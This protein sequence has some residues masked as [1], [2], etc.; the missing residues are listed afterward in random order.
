VFSFPGRLRVQG[1]NEDKKKRNRQCSS[2]FHQ[3]SGLRAM[4]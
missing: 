1:G 4:V 2:G 3:M